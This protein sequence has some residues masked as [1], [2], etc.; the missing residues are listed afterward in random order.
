MIRI[1]TNQFTA[2]FAVLLAL[3]GVVTTVAA[4]SPALIPLQG[5]LVDA[6]GAPID[7]DADV[8]F[9]LY[10]TETDG[11]PLFEE[12][13][14]L[15][16]SDGGFVAY[17]GD[18]TSL[19]LAWFRDNDAIFL[20]A[21][22]AGDEEMM[23]RVLL[24]S[25]PWSGFALYCGDAATLGGASA[26]D[27]ASATHVHAF[28]EITDVPADLAD[29]DSDTLGALSCTDGQVAAASGGTWNCSNANMYT[30]GTGLTLVGN[31][32]AFDATYGDGRYLSASYTPTWSALTGVPGG[33]ADG[34]D[35]DTTYTAGT[36]ISLSSGSFGLD[37]A[38]TDGRY[39]ALGGNAGTSPATHFIGTTDDVALEL[40]ANNTRVL[41]L[42]SFTVDG[43]HIDGIVDVIGGSA[44]NS[45]ARAGATIAGGGRTS[46]PNQVNSVFGSVGGGY[47]NV[48]GDSTDTT[49]G[50]T[51]GGGI[52][53]TAPGNRAVIAGGLNNIAS[54][55]NAVVG[56][57]GANTAS[58]ENSVTAG[59]VNNTA[60]A[61][62]STV[63]GGEGHTASGLSSVVAGGAV[64]SALGWA[65]T[66]SGGTGN[67]TGTAQGST[68]SGGQDN[69]STARASTVAGGM[70]NIAEGAYS[71]VLG[72]LANHA[73]GAYSVAGGRRAHAELN[74][75]VVF[76]DAT[77]ADVTCGAA[78]RFVARASGGVFFY[79]NAGLT[80][81]AS[82][83][84]GGGSWTSLSDR[85]AKEDV[86][87][88][89]PLEVLSKVEALEVGSWRYREETSRARHMG[90]MA[91]D[92]YAAFGLGDSERHIT[93]VDADGVALAAIQG[94]ALKNRQ[95]STTVT[96]HDA[97]IVKLTAEN[98]E[99]R[100]QLRE[101][102]AQLDRLQSAF[103]STQSSAS[104]QG[105]RESTWKQGVAPG[106]IVLLL[107]AGL[108]GGLA[109][110]RRTE[111]RVGV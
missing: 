80:A 38:Y 69:G 71:T 103:D 59:G 16:L 104:A 110:R 85:N 21:Q 94:L 28:S 58:G 84:A 67:V 53:N 91:Q 50:Q 19:D 95:Q 47:G 3:G 6:D 49:G 108:F 81:G 15:M 26:T 46:G 24:A 63:S 51:I 89:D 8:T 31:S 44:A 14:S 92:F 13:Q 88:V 106:L 109:R 42:S 72:G 78:N 105:T 57:G 62:A 99:L 33:F 82:L 48:V 5:V 25:V 66:V 20:S 41:R 90:P 76:G 29:G 11:V 22:V 61:R 64:N 12:T 2:V 35:N 7:G 107:G 54:G 40:R 70:D 32:F 79:T 68:I 65:T 39:W 93:T 102:S 74:G 101:V 10:T 97:A 18:V 9:R 4:Q 27:F 43:N 100:S 1:A 30:A 77:D 45:N 37:L 75:C 83:A 87:D 56:G 96:R 23:P 52:N 55:R 60:S 98:E 34:V 86:Q 17:L 111:S 36:G 73:S